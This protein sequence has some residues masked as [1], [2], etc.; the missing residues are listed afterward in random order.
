MEEEVKKKKGIKINGKKRK[1]EKEHK[2]A[3]GFSLPKQKLRCPKRD[4]QCSNSSVSF[5]CE[6]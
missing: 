1:V 3:I 6:R 4:S 2:T 5:D